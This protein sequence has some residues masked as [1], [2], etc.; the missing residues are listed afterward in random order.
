MS[1]SASVI[2]PY[3]ECAIFIKASDLNRQTGNRGQSES[4]QYAW[5][6]NSAKSVVVKLNPISMTMN[7]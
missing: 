6:Q 2:F 7:T 4:Q 1:R 3:V 5:L